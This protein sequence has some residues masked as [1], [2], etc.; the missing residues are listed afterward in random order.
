M[1]VCVLKL[2]LI[3]PLNY[4]DTCCVVFLLSLFGALRTNLVCV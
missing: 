2:Q 3:Y 4:F 1:S